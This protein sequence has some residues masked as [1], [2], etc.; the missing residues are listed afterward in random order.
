MIVDEIPWLSPLAMAPAFYGVPGA[1]LFGAGAGL[2]NSGWGDAGWANTGWGGGQWSVFVADP[3]GVF[4]VRAGRAYIDARPQ[5]GPPFQALARFLNAR[6][7]DW[8]DHRRCFSQSTST[9]QSTGASQSTKD[10]KSG[11]LL[12]DTLLRQA[13]FLSGVAGFVGY[14][15][16]TALE[17]SVDMPSS[18]Y[19]LADMA[20]G[21]YDGAMVFHWPSKRAFV[22]AKTKARA[23][24]FKRALKKGQ[25]DQA[26]DP[27]RPIVK[28]GTAFKDVSSNF[29]AP[30]YRA[31]VA[32]IVEQI[33]NG[34][35]FQANIAQQLSV[36]LPDYTLVELW[37][38]LQAKS[39]APFGAL[40]QYDEGA[41]FSNSPER[42]FS[43]DEN[44]KIICEP[45]KGTRPRGATPQEDARQAQNLLKDEKDRAE[46]IM[47][48]DL[49]RNDLS[50]ICHDETIKAD[51]VC[52]LAQFETV[53]HL[54]SKVSGVLKD[55][56]DASEA[57]AAL[58]PCG[59]ITGA[60]KIEAM[61]AIARTEKIGRGPYCGA[62][63]YIDDRGGAD[64][65]VAIRTMMAI[66]KGDGIA[67]AFP[68]GGGVT[69]RSDPSQEYQETLDKAAFFFDA[70]GV[71][72]DER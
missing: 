53:Q 54:V 15:M 11:D 24:I 10:Q 64:F 6:R 45:I 29:T 5:D 27:L 63:G 3:V 59:S 57:L 47:I 39:A 22:V 33:L 16:G 43:I 1:H 12:S 68:V 70:L 28:D 30:A 66:P 26:T 32:N 62:I 20:F 19:P 13:P 14:E 46:N 31:A 2:R 69:H 8:A 9:T 42:F 34:A 55:G 37:A 50:R 41:I 48:V 52:A 65:S 17:P 25:A 56:V 44:R 40:L 58:F 49:M 4:E 21:A 60:P 72:D 51:E 71:K 38:E 23:E 36:D 18:P 61:K 7:D 35:F 67:A